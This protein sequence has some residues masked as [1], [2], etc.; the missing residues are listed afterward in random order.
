MTSPRTYDALGAYMAV[1]AVADAIPLPFIAKVLDDVNFPRQYRWIFPVVKGAAAIGLFSM[2]WFP[3]LARLTTAM[4]TL[5]FVLAV[6]FHVKSRDI[7]PAAVGAATCAATF[8]VVTARG[9]SAS[10]A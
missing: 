4:A 7:G 9:P 6:A 5:Y 2:R 1:S 8:G 3:W 10:S